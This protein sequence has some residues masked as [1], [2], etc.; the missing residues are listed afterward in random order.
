MARVSLGRVIA[1]FFVSA[2]MALAI[3]FFFAMPVKLAN[4]QSDVCVPAEALV[5]NLA[6]NPTTQRVI[7]IGSERTRV[8]LEAST[9]MTPPPEDDMILMV[10][11]DGRA[12]IIPISGG[13]AC[14]SFGVIPVPPQ[15]HQEGMQAVFGAPA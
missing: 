4:A 9:G 5:E 3:L 11:V 15:A 12:S 7:L 10:T 14:A 13:I 6:E 2:V 1:V 8:Y